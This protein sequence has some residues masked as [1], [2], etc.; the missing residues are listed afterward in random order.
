M[1]NRIYI[2]DD[3]DGMR[4]FLRKMLAGKGYAVEDFGG[5]KALLA[6]LAENPDDA[7][8]LLLDIR[9]TDMDGL[10]V[11]RRL[12]EQAPKV[13][14]VMMTGHGSIESAV[15]AMK[16]GALDYLTKPFP[17]EKLFSVVE[18]AM[19][20]ERL[21]RENSTL[22]QE[23]KDRIYPET[24]IVKSNAFR[25]V[26]KM[27]LK[28][29]GTDSNVLILGESGTGKELIAGTVHYHG[30]RS[31][32][33]F[34]AINC[35]ALTETLLESQL[36]G[37][38]KGAFTGATQI[39]KGL[40]EEA[41][42][43]TLFLD[44]IGELSLPLQAKLLRVLENGEY[45]PVGATRPR[46]TNVRFL[47]ATNKDLELEAAQGRFRQD[48]Y[49]RLNVFSLQLPPLRERTE[50][51]RPLVQHFLRKASAKTGRQVSG[52]SP[53]ALRILEAYEWPGNV[54]ELENV[55]ER[56]VIL[57]PADQLTPDLFPLKVSAASGSQ[58]GLSTDSLNLRELERVQVLRALAQTGWNKSQAALLLGVTRKTL[59]K[60]IKDFD[61]TPD[62]TA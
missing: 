57:A 4:R 38:V 18:L 26:Y 9:M 1:H 43:G 23:L 56:A 53:Q 54:R 47:A 3:E 13:P 15:E 5:G 31:E 59:D 51:I 60:K 36:F 46:K 42:G 52:I 19:D 44:E 35:A 62:T 24:I 14:V 29:A 55:I 30:A 39:Q 22:K 21:Q 41:D 11:L 48:L 8:L 27:A 12:R 49:Y 32:R 25:D 20:R 2:C 34:L 28:V 17:Q 16:L 10:D 50:D 58:A 61:L 45:L 33:L 37:H 7:G 40:L 6:A